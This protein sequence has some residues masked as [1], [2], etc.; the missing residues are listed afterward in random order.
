MADNIESQNIATNDPISYVKKDVDK[1]LFLNY[2]SS[3]E[4]SE[5]ISKL[6]NKKSSGY[7]LISNHILKSTNHSTYCTLS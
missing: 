2:T 4:I 7:D 6:E 3:S 1:S 5:R